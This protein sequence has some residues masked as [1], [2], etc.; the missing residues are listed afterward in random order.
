MATI[1]EGSCTVP[2]DKATVWTRL[3][4]PVVLK[5]CIGGLHALE[6]TSPTDFAMVAKVKLGIFTATFA[7]AITLH[8]VD[9]PHG[10]RLLGE[11]KGGIAGYARGS[12]DIRLTD[13][14]DGT[15]VAY[16]VEAA[17]GGKLAHFGGKLIDGVAQRL[18][19]RFFATFTSDLSRSA[20]E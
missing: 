11:G 16:A 20:A 9:A 7:G 6:K 10:C 1:L 12:A 19:A 2:A 17:L 3:N 15:Q 8:D 5:R 14:P 13:V 4:D 18:I